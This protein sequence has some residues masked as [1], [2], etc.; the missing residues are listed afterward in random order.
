MDL[1]SMLRND[2]KFAAKYI[3]WLSVVEYVPALKKKTRNIHIS[4]IDQ[5]LPLVSWK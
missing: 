1:Q 3:Y 5:I 2:S 4:L